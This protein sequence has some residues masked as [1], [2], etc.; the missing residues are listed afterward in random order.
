MGLPPLIPDPSPSHTV[1]ENLPPPPP[2][3]PFPRRFTF[4]IGLVLY[5]KWLVSPCHPGQALCGASF[6]FP[7]FITLCGFSFCAA[8]AHCVCWSYGWWLED[9]L[10]PWT[11]FGLFTLTAPISFFA[12]IDIAL[13]NLSYVYLNSNFVEMV[14]PSSLVWT[15][16]LSLILRLTQ[17]SLLLFASIFVMFGGQL[18]IA[19]SSGPE[20]N[21]KGARRRSRP[22]GFVRGHMRPMALCGS[23]RACVTALLLPSS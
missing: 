23:F 18:I 10:G 7:V 20:F 22:P 5:N 16:V 19:A 21:L 17:P 3:S 14:K 15:L 11:W 6:P 8:A 4:S 2:S 13:T 9:T 12:G 1:V